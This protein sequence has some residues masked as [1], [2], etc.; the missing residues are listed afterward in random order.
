[1][2]RSQSIRLMGYS[3]ESG[4]IR[5]VQARR[6]AAN[7]G[8]FIL[9][10][11]LEPRCLLTTINLG[12]LVSAGFTIF[13]ADA[14]DESGRSVSNAGDVNG[15]G[16]DDL[17]IGARGADGTGNA[18]P[19]VGES[20]LIFGR[21]SQPTTTT[22]DLANLG[23]AGIKIIGV[24]PLD[25][26]GFSVSGAGDVN[27]DG[28]DDLLIG[29]PGADGAS[30][31]QDF[32]GECYVVFGGAS[33]PS[34]IN[35]ATLGVGGVTIYGVDAIDQIGR[36]VSSAGDVNG[37]GFDD[38]LIG[39][40]GGDGASNAKSDAGESYLIFGGASL[41]STIE[42][43]NLGSAGITFFG[44]DSGDLSGFLVSNA[45]DVNGDGFDDLL[46]G[47]PGGDGTGN[48]EPD[49]GECYLIFGG[50]SLPTTIELANLGSVGITIYGG[51][52]GDL[53]GRSV[54]SAGDVNG[55][56][57][58]DLIIGAFVGD[59][60]D[61]AKTDAGESYVIFGR[62][63]LPTTINLANLGS[64]GITFLG[65]DANDWSGHSVSSAGDINGD[66]FDDLLIGAHQGD[67]A[68]NT[69]MDAGESYVIFGS[70][71]LPATIDLANLSLAGITIFGVEAGDQSGSS[72]SNAGDVNGDGFDDLLI[73][74]YRTGAAAN[75]KPLAGESY[76][77]FGRDFTDSV[78]QLGTVAAETLTGNASAN[79]ISGARGNDTLIGNGGADVIYGGIGDDVLAISDMTFQR[80]DGGNGAD[81]LRLDGS[82]LTLDLTT[83]ADNKLTNI[84]TI[85]IRGSG[86]NR[87][88]LN[89]RE[90][91][92]LTTNS[93]PAH[94]ANTLTVRRDPGDSVNMGVGWTPGADTLIAGVSYRTFTQGAAK[95]LLE[96]N[97]APT[98][99]NAIA[100]Q[101]AT[102]ESEFAFT[103]AATT[104]NDV[105]AGDSLTYSATR[106]DGSALPSWLMFTPATRRFSGTPLISDVG[107]LSIKVTAT[108]T[109]NTTATDTFNIVVTKSASAFNGGYTGSYRGALTDPRS[110]SL[111][112]IITD[113]S[114]TATITDGGVTGY[115]P[116]TGGTGTGTVD[117]DGNLEVSDS[118]PIFIPGVGVFDVT[119]VFSGQLV[120]SAA[121]V[122]GSGTIDISGDLTGTGTWTATR[123]ITT[124]NKAPVFEIS[125]SPDQTV[126]EDAGVRIVKGF[127]TGIA[128]GDIDKIQTSKFLVTTNNDS[129]FLTKPAINTTTG[130]LTYTPAPNA[131]GTATA[132]VKL[133]D[134]G[135]TA[136]GGVD[137]S[138]SKTF[139]ITVTPVNDGPPT[140]TAIKDVAVDEDK[141][142][143]AIAFKVDDPDDKLV[144]LNALT[145]TATSSNTDLVP[146]SPTNIVVGGSAG[147]RTIKLVPLANQF[148]MTTITVTATD[149]SGA[150]ATETFVLTVRSINDV[151]V[152]T[153]GTFTINEYTTNNAV[154]GTAEA[155]DPEGN[156]ITSFTITG[157]NVGNA[158]K[159]DS[160]TGEI[161]VNDA[162]KIDFEAR[163]SYTLTIKATDALGAAGSKATETGP[164]TIN[165]E[166]QSFNLTVAT[167]NIDNT[168]TVSKIGNNLVVR[169][170]G[171]D[172]I[173][174]TSLEDVG[175][176]T[177]TGGTAK[178]KVVLE[179]SLNSAGSPAFHKFVG[180]I[181]VNG[182]GGDDKLDASKITVAT[183]GITYNGGLGNDTAIGGSG[184]DIL[185][186]GD[187]SDSLDGGVGNDVLNGGRGD[188]QLL[189]GAGNDTYLF[190]DTDTVETDTLSE[191]ANA[192]TD[193]LDFSNL[194]VAVT[195]KLT[196]ETALAIHNNRTI[197]T[198]STGTAKLAPNF[199]NVIGG[200]GDDQIL[201]NAANNSLLGGAGRDTIIGGAG[202]DTLR[203][204]DDDDTLIGGLGADSVFGDS[205]ND[206]GLGG[207]GSVA[208]GS[209]GVKD[210]GDLLNASLETINE[211][212][213]TVF[214]FEL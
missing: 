148:G 25:E 128:D 199:E 180:Q 3:I 211:A 201:G 23:T 83:L 206:L 154:V 111:A 50:A 92:N 107:T 56:G 18:K 123:T 207:R 53:A 182:N 127:A 36:S 35:L 7:A 146:N 109:S 42:L 39:A 6:R 181:I 166:N 41:P 121:G 136:R 167:V 159:I 52:V 71:S 85:D 134:N 147:S 204:G 22:I 4:G 40:P 96:Q 129:L 138:A 93:N 131:N 203:G 14:N 64:A 169:R 192:G 74:A 142:T 126:F 63:S 77:I 133:K 2:L 13:G 99:A 47:A 208:R 81:T 200:A 185:V 95:F 157:G 87:L 212:F 151:P 89:A 183:F 152:V 144:N 193:V 191:I 214:A 44:A 15:D 37:D 140:I 116:A 137:T 86:P 19:Y 9:A 177:I 115:L 48:A 113:R 79:V 170:G 97:S 62:T 135:G 118:G 145:V 20:Y 124:P 205:G 179:A 58:D 54:S 101:N 78:T 202:N 194:T 66:G 32:A 33:L 104:F 103:F 34:T 143:G 165:V 110:I 209:T 24:D 163:S 61:N 100:D 12:S 130:T 59:G 195:V 98:L 122:T 132:T 46:I 70:T 155:V 108:D 29:A 16:F 1:M 120:R 188:D 69:K 28:F 176:L 186:G 31:T 164:V 102:E 49:A 76:L 172:V 55:D 8:E 141:A 11:C 73:G 68:S 17:L 21:V 196:S 171:V 38:L 45:G 210:T 94:T 91:L 161:R 57:F 139:L 156:P 72:V 174:P 184:N 106:L 80:L 75:L 125:A 213:A 198:S 160:A 30:N 60:A 90:V 187:G 67:G 175:S 26:S 178:D 197:K 82:G 112:S 105:N 168:M 158:F 27:G 173:T 117:G 10:E 162:S 84:E 65:V 189:G 114:F 43:A 5:T 150:T 149:S 190:A 119:I 153:A 88:T 51:D